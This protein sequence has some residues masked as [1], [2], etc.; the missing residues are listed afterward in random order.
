MAR[1]TAGTNTQIS[2]TSYSDQRSQTYLTIAGWMRRGAS[3]TVQTWGWSAGSSD[4]VNFLWFSDNNMYAAINGFRQISKNATGWHHWAMTFDGS[5]GVQANRGLVYYDGVAEAAGSVSWPTATSA[6]LSTFRVG[7]SE[8]NNAW[9]TGGFAE[10]AVWTET[11]NAAEIASLA[12]GF[13]PD[14][15]R[16]SS[17]MLYLPLVRDIGDPVA[18]ATLTDASSTV[19]DHPRVYA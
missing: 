4:R 8:T 19:T 9:S 18:A 3:G 12:K 17:L 14:K 11:L 2:S 13:T 15:I 5:I 7:R 10:L 6:T 1:D 16:P